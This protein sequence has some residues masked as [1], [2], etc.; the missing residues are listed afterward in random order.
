ML[1]EIRRGSKLR[2]EYND[3]DV[4]LLERHLHLRKIVEFLLWK[5]VKMIQKVVKCKQISTYWTE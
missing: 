5:G 1:L 2:E 3:R 4:N